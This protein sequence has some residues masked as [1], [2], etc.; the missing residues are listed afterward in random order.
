MVAQ[1]LGVAGQMGLALV[2]VIGAGRVEEG[3]EWDLGVDDDP[4]TTDQLDDQVGPLHRVVARHGVD[5]FGEVAAVDHPG[6]LDRSAQ[7]HLTPSSTDL[8]PA[9]RRGQRLG[10]ASQRVGG[11]SH[12][13]DLLAELAL[14]GG[15]LV[16]EV[17][18]L[19]AEAVQAQDQLGPVEARVEQ[20]GGVRR[21]RARPEHANHRTEPEPQGQHQHHR[22]HH[23]HQCARDHRQGADVCE[24]MVRPIDNR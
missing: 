16:V 17:A 10:L 4:P 9:Q 19:V 22:H 18:H 1:L 8:G 3:V 6:Q 15:P 2:V 5:L 21:S 24:A 11:Q 20:G 23:A 12:V 7:V 14:P 13:V